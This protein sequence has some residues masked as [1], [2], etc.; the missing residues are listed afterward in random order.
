[1]NNKN[2]NNIQQMYFDK[3]KRI[4]KYF[5]EKQESIK[6]SVAQNN[7]VQIVSALIQN[8]KIKDDKDIEEKLERF[9]RFLYEM[10]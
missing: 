7:A 10:R 6:F 5:N 1:M 3:Q 2:M 4:D 8:G 9:T